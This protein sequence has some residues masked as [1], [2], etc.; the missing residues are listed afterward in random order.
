MSSLQPLETRDS[1]GCTYFQ[2]CAWNAQRADIMGPMSTGENDYTPYAPPVAVDAERPT[3][4]LPAA[5]AAPEPVAWLLWPARLIAFCVVLPVRA[6]WEALRGAA[7]AVGAGLEKVFAFLG[8]VL[9]AL[10]RPVVT[11]LLAPLRWLGRTLLLP[12]AAA[13]GGVVAWL[14]ERLVLPVVRALAAACSAAC[15]AIVG[16]V[17]A[18]LRGLWHGG[19]GT[20][21]RAVARAIAWAWH[22]AGRV[23]ALVGRILAWPFVQ[24]HRHVLTPVGHAIRSVWRTVVL[25][26][27]RAVRRTTSAAVT[28]VRA[29]VRDASR[30][31]GNQVRRALGRPPR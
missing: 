7:R 31:V 3:G 19:L 22:A 13:V 23:L 28:A 2:A 29:S 24:L 4:P 6:I 10:L 20:V 17:V 15:S 14:G 21:L 8:R 25:T 9:L 26:P 5:P 30:Q 1:G 16:A 27:W 18:L 12:L 11:V